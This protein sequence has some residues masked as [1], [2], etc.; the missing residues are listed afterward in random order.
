MI[1]NN[2][3]NAKILNQ[4]QTVRIYIRGIEFVIIT[5]FILLDKIIVTR[6][7]ILSIFIIL[8]I[9]NI[10]VTGTRAVI[11]TAGIVVFLYFLQSIKQKRFLKSILMLIIVSLGVFYSF[12]IIDTLYEL[13]LRESTLQGGNIDTRLIAMG[14]F[15]NNYFPNF[16]TYIYGQWCSQ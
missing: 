15:M 14:Y 5:L 8:F 7:I 1:D 4:R 13:F 6:N 10:I 16:I 3:V 11:F 9:T 2:I 12:N